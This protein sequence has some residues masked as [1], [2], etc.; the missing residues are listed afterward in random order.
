MK[1]WVPFGAKFYLK[2]VK[3]QSRLLKLQLISKFSNFS[4]DNFVKQITTRYE[5]TGFSDRQDR[6]RVQ[7]PSPYDMSPNQRLTSH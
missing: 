7:I 6:V 5:A 4:L 1:P 2:R 3:F